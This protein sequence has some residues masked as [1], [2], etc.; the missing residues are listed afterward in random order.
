[1]H[2]YNYV[3]VVQGLLQQFEFNAMFGGLKE[4]RR[5][6]ETPVEAVNPPF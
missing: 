1:M 3:L 4:G 6:E 2:M 5:R